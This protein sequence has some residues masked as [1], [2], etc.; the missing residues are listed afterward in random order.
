MSEAKCSKCQNRQKAAVTKLGAVRTPRGWKLHLGQLHCS[1]CWHKSYRL[2]AVTF[3]VRGPIGAEWKDLREAL[4]AA[5][6][7]STHLA[8]W[9]VSELARADSFRKP[10]ET[11][12]AKAPT[13]NLYQLW[14]QHFEREQWGG[15]AQSANAILHGIQGRYMKR[16]YNVLWLQDESLPNVRY[17][18]PYPVHNKAW[19]AEYH[20]LEGP[21][22]GKTKVPA[23]S[24][25]IGDRRWLLQLRGGPERRRQ[26]KAFAQIADGTAI[27]GELAIYRQRSS[28]GAHRA[29]MT[30]RNG[31]GGGAKFQSRVMLKLV[32]WLPREAQRI[33][34]Y[35]L[36]KTLKVRTGTH[37]FLVAECEGR[38]WTLRNNQVRGWV[39]AH[40]RKLQYM[41]DDSQFERRHPRRKRR[42]TLDHY[43]KICDRYAKRIKTHKDEVAAWLIMHAI[44]CRAGRIVFDGSVRSYCEGYPWDGL[45]DQIAHNCDKN[46]ITFQLASTDV[47]KEDDGQNATEEL[48]AS[49]VAE[50]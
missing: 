20:E 23:V 48:A 25:V 16:R 10:G 6:S 33:P 13:V 38:Y 41:A 5:W 37:C 2:C 28:L 1:D 17:P 19:K 46:A 40:A 8:N 21:N 9:A 47:V 11:K 12:L 22:G 44:R 7:R 35:I 39:R 49:S 4:S 36:E 31:S 45:R 14:Q 26:L 32:A 15:A 30:D 50:E 34:A 42:Q 24:V 18:Y 3:P 29:T 27:S 43:D